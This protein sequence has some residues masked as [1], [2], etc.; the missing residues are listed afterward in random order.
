MIIPTSKRDILVVDDNREAAD[1]MVEL[2]T[3]CGHTA[4]QAY[5]GLEGVEAALRFTPEII[6]LDLSM[7][8]MDGFEVAR[9]LRELEMFRATVLVAFTALTDEVTL[10]RVRV[11]GFDFHLPK[12]VSIGRVMDVISK[13]RHQIETAKVATSDSFGL[14]GNRA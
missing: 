4:S 2:L 12:P 6:L 8:I 10:R 14:T 7:P 11:E 1:L 13:A 3:L 9:K 5:S